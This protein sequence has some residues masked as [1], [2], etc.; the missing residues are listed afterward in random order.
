MDAGTAGSWRRI[1]H[2]C[3]LQKNRDGDSYSANGRGIGL[4]RYHSE[5]VRKPGSKGAKDLPPC[6]A[7]VQQNAQKTPSWAESDRRWQSKTIPDSRALIRLGLGPDSGH[8]LNPESAMTMSPAPSVQHT[9]SRSAAKLSSASMSTSGN[10]MPASSVQVSSPAA[11]M[12][13]VPTR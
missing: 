7:S 13:T 3:E 10:S 8:L 1:E 9:S 5:D 11:S 12:S 6:Y 4:W 2:G